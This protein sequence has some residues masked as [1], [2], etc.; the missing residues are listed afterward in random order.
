MRARRFLLVIFSIVLFFACRYAGKIE[1]TDDV[2]SSM[3]DSTYKAVLAD[4]G[5]TAT[6]TEIATYYVKN[7]RKYDK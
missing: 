4:L 7:Q 6:E 5:G 3:S 2:I 1:F